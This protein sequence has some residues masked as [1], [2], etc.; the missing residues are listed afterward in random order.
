MLYLI[1]LGLSDEKDISLRGLEAL[2]GSERVYFESYTGFFNGDL[3]RLEALCGRKI[4][5]LSR[6]DVE[7]HPEENVLKN[8]LQGTVSL[9]VL[10]D[11]MVATTHVD[12]LLRARKKGIRT[13]VIHASSV[14]SAVA[15]TGL[16]IYK[17]GRT[18]T[19]AYPEGSYF[20][21][22]P[23]D[24]LGENRERGLHT[25]CLLDVKAA[26]GRYM[27]VNE[28]I[29]L[30]LRMESEKREGRF[31]GSTPC[32][33]VARLG[34]DS[35]IKYGPVIKLLEAD[36][37]RPPHVLIVPGKLHYMEEEALKAFS[38]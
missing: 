38:D 19:I 6:G 1:G 17:F 29:G 9:L 35:T 21:T 14:Y 36:F 31:S 4:K 23:Y 11:P 26:E 15:E 10:G 12:L 8:A 37:G 16:Q 5:A 20:P 25:L 2:K 34:G 13:I 27:T 3:G 22:S 32:V 7:E 33:G 18:T 28:A 24:A 30:L